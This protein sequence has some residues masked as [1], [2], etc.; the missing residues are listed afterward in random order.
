M[1][2][3]PKWT[4]ALGIIYQNIVEVRH[5]IEKTRPTVFSKKTKNKKKQKTKQTNKQKNNGHVKS[6]YYIQ[7]RWD[8][9]EYN[10]NLKQ[11]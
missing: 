7:G 4:K 10:N 9:R 11:Y 3:Q 2:G 5:A 1:L 8:H 6:L